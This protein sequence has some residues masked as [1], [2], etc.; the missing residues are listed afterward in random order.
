[1]AK[2]LKYC[3]FSTLTWFDRDVNVAFPVGSLTL[4]RHLKLIQADSQLSGAEEESPAFNIRLQQKLQLLMTLI[5]TLLSFSVL[6]C[7]SS[8]TPL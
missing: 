3:F 8:I 7:L 1:M 5:G 4:H 6:L 2:E